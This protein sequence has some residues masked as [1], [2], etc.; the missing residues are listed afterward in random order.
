MANHAK[1]Q[2]ANDHVPSK[3]VEEDTTQS[4]PKI[5]KKY[6]PA[7]LQIKHSNVDTATP[8][9]SGPITMSTV[10]QE[11]IDV[12][13]PVTPMKGPS[14][15]GFK[16]P[17]SVNYTSASGTPTSATKRKRNAHIA[18]AKKR[19][20]G[21]SP[22]HNLTP[23]KKKSKKDHVSR[24]ANESSGS[25]SGTPRDDRKNNGKKLASVK[26]KAKAAASAAPFRRSQ[27]SGA[28]N[29]DIGTRAGKV[30]SPAVQE[31]YD[32]F[33]HDSEDHSEFETQQGP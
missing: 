20:E 8:N 23:V 32:M 26:S 1:E 9:A 16:T 25:D 19:V 18:W 10:K 17:S 27:R 14:S 21:S 28:A 22:K 24:R 11:D 4:W 2:V 5:I 7:P 29:K 31:I 30:Y 15:P 13:P 6:R 33:G 3:D 12:E